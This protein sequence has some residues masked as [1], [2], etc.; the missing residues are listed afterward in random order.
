VTASILDLI[1]ELVD[2]LSVLRGLRLVMNLQR[3]SPRPSSINFR[4]HSAFLV[5]GF[6]AGTVMDNDASPP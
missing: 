2:G 6:E 1:F 3:E 5:E 4:S